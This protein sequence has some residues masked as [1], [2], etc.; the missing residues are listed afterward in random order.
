MAR[1]HWAQFPLDHGEPAPARDEFVG[2]T[3]ARS[4]AS[5]PA[6]L[7]WAGLARPSL[8]AGDLV[9]AEAQS[10]QALGALDGGG[11]G[12]CRGEEQKCDL[13]D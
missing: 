2:V 13:G 11:H 1:V 8:A 9:A 4:S 12:P 6:A 5:A 10:A 3:E 7:A